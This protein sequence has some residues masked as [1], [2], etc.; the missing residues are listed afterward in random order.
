MYKDSFFIILG[1]ASKASTSRQAEV[2]VIE[3]TSLEAGSYQEDP[4]CLIQSI[5]KK[6]AT[7]APPSES[8]NTNSE[9]TVDVCKK[10]VESPKKSIGGAK[11]GGVVKKSKLGDRKKI[12]RWD[13]FNPNEAFTNG[14]QSDIRKPSEV[15]KITQYRKLIGNT[16][17]VSFQYHSFD[18]KH[19]DEKKYPAIMFINQYTIS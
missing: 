16:R 4:D 10:N 7:S 3:E 5:N 6:F 8:S 17:S 18:D 11:N 9:Q 19:G 1:N 2:E 15:Q 13:F 14:V 12:E